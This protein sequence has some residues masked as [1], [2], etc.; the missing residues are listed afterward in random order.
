MIVNITDCTGVKIGYLEMV[1]TSVISV[2]FD[3]SSVMILIQN[4]HMK[5]IQKTYGIHKHMVIHTQHMYN[6]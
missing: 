1:H 4:W 2:L 6:S 3:K 5:T